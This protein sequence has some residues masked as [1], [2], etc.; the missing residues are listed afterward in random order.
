MKVEVLAKDVK[1]GDVLPSGRL[2]TG[3]QTTST[4]A[5][6]Y[7]LKVMGDFSGW[8]GSLPL[9][10]PLTVERP[11]PTYTVTVELTKEQLKALSNTTGSG[12]NAQE[13]WFLTE[14]LRNACAAALA[15]IEESETP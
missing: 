13:Y 1:V 7:A 4:H 12:M 5:M 15:S 6:I 8:Y 11:E 14:P 10:L 3:V 9:D 2:C